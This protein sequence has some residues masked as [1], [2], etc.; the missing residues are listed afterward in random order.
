TFGWHLNAAICRDTALGEKEAPPPP[1]GFEIRFVKPRTSIP[2]SC[3]PATGLY[4]LDLRKWQNGTTLRDTFKLNTNNLDQATLPITIS[5]APIS[6]LSLTTLT[7]S[8][9]ITPQTINMLNTNSIVLNNADITFVRIFAETILGVSEVGGVPTEYKLEQNYPNPFN[10]STD[11]L[12]SLKNSSNVNIKVY[13]V[14]GRLVTKL[15]DEDLPAGNYKAS[16]DGLNTDAN[17]VSSGI[18][19]VKMTAFSQTGELFTDIKKAILLR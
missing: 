5:W 19:F 16:W 11:F 9:T 10:P 17:S 8:E 1:L 4:E 13:D 7:M 12:F 15:L 14:M 3:F 2:D 6:N 18:Y